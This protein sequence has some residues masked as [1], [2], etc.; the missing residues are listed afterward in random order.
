M[1]DC[2]YFSTSYSRGATTFLT[3]TT[4]PQ[5]RSRARC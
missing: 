4:P 1:P 5:N 3:A 2:E